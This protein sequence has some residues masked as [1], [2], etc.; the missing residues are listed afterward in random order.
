ML[1]TKNKVPLVSMVNFEISFSFLQKGTKFNFLENVSKPE[2]TVSVVNLFKKKT[3]RGYLFK[4]IYRN[5]IGIFLLN[6]LQ[7]KIKINYIYL[8]RK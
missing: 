7:D 6:Q 5:S 1:V 3:K 8:C 4:Y 2:R